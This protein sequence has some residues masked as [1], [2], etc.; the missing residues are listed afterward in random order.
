MSDPSSES[1]PIPDP[2]RT[3]LPK[4]G[5]SGFCLLVGLVTFAI[6][7][8]CSATGTASSWAWGTVWFSVAILLVVL[9]IWFWDQTAS[10]HWRRKLLLT[11]VVILLMGMLSYIPITKQYKVEHSTMLQALTAKEIAAEVAKLPRQKDVERPAM[12]S[13]TT[14]PKVEV[15][16]AAP[17][18]GAEIEMKFFMSGPQKQLAFCFANRSGSLVSDAHW[19]I[20]SWNRRLGQSNSL[21]VP[22][23]PI[24][25]IKAHEETGL[26]A[27]FPQNP[28]PEVENGDELVGTAAVDCPICIPRS[29]VLDVIW[30]DHGWYGDATSTFNGKLVM[31]GKGTSTEAREAYFTQALA[32]VPQ[33]NRINMDEK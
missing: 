7:Q 26:T 31:P 23:Y 12:E 4:F 6:Q 18:T 8:G 33:S 10:H 29:Y 3:I 9:A 22:V 13:S 28:P 21:P 15:H 32:L 27:V 14:T 30:G 20:V 11:I 24:N 2:P 5:F 17:K 19:A 25:W 16:K 1:S